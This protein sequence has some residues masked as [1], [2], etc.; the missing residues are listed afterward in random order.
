[1]MMHVHRNAK[2]ADE[3]YETKQNNYIDFSFCIQAFDF[4]IFSMLASLTFFGTIFREILSRDV[5]GQA[6]SL[7]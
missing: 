1:M 5:G 4:L 7:S 2:F 6:D 3:S